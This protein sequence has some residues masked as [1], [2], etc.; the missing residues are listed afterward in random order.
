MTLINEVSKAT[1]VIDDEQI[2]NND[3]NSEEY[4][5]KYK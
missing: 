4:K 3:I 5:S 1:I 2:A